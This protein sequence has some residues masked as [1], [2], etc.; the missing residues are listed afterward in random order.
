MQKKK[1]SLAKKVE[2]TL[3]I[4]RVSDEDVVLV[5]EQVIVEHTNGRSFSVE[6]P[7]KENRYYLSEM[8]KILKGMCE[9]SSGYLT[10]YK[11]GSVIVIIVN[12]PAEDENG[13]WNGEYNKDYF[14]G[15]YVT[16][17]HHRFGLIQPRI[18][19][20]GMIESYD[21]NGRTLTPT[22]RTGA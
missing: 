16:V 1:E 2:S 18:Q 6:I 14:V 12:V 19:L 10:A 7:T 5:P 9:N 8:K 4:I 22:F 15:D 3:D 11:D 20:I 21:Q 13:E 17:E